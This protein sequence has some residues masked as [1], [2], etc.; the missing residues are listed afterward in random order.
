M[1]RARAH[2]NFVWS[3]SQG[4]QNIASVLTN[5][6]ALSGPAVNDEFKTERK[7]PAAEG[8]LSRDRQISLIK[9]MPVASMLGLS[10]YRLVFH[11]ETMTLAD[12][13]KPT[14]L[15]PAAS[16]CHAE[17]VLTDLTYARVYAN[18]HNLKTFWV[19]RDFGSGS[20]LVRRTGVPEETKLTV[21][22]KEDERTE[23]DFISDLERAF[24]TNLQEFASSMEAKPKK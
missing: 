20:T 8:P 19:L 1:M 11:T 16:P 12:I 5:S 23:A 6:A 3:A 2:D 13:R 15:S 22:T 4:Q 14:A 10:N 7:G 17:L 18:G 9:A 21:S 24:T